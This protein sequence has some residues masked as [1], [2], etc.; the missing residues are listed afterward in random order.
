[1]RHLKHAL[2]RRLVHLSLHG[3][4]GRE[5]LHACEDETI[6][7]LQYIIRGT[8]KGRL[9]SR[10]Y[11]FNSFGMLSIY[12]IVVILNFILYVQPYVSRPLFS[13]TVPAA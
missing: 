8:T 13:Y 1:M 3:G 4:K 5:L 7:R 2:I 10:L 9:Q 11:I 6:D 12:A